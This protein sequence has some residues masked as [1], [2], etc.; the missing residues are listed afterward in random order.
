MSEEIK[1]AAQQTQYPTAPCRELHFHER[2]DSEKIQK[3]AE[4]IEL[5]SMKVRD[6]C[7]MVNALKEHS[8][9][10]D[11][12]VVPLR[13]PKDGYSEYVAESYFLKNPLNRERQGL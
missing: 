3:L 11:R 7:S 1:D 12:I 8:H 9:S 13:E 4:V 10:A 6:A 2:S 5:L